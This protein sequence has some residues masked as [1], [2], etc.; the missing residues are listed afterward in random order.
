M[1]KSYVSAIKKVL[2]TDGYSWCEDKFLLNA[3]TNACKIQNDKVQTRLPI[4][5]NLLEVMLCEIE[6]IYSTTQPYLEI[7][8][9]AIFV[10][11]YY[12]MLRISE[13]TSSPHAARAKN[14]HVGSNKNK[15]MIVL[16]SSKTHGKNKYPQ[17]VKIDALDDYITNLGRQ[18]AFCPFEIV[19][20]YS[21][22]RGGYY[23]DDEQF[24]IFSDHS[25]VK[26]THV[27]NLM[28]TIFNR[29]NL[30][31][32]LYGTHS[33]RIGRAS[34]LLKQKEPIDNIKQLGRWKSNAVY[35]Y[36]RD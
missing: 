12:G 21:N 35:R 17:L 2:Q 25:P 29:L 19:R 33:F 28:K 5:I 7:L 14:V 13:L 30:K 32:S 10:L 20:N 26:P 6:R 16:Y 3:L 9:K 11:A 1:L 4:R 15:I 23:T 24:F 8:Y 27:R 22:T 31:G 34:D 18:G 36:L